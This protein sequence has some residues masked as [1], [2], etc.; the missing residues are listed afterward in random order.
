[1]LYVYVN[2]LVDAVLVVPLHLE[3]T[4]RLNHGRGWVGFTAATGTNTYQVHDILD[5][6]FDSLRKDKEGVE[7]T[8]VDGE[9][10]HRCSG[11]AD[12]VHF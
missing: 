3:A 2:N 4:L 10:A 1:M 12:C 9:G 5:W 6:R 7:P 11:S 8:L